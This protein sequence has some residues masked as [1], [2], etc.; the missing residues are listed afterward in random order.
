[1]QL[2]RR[3]LS[4]PISH[5]GTLDKSLREPSGVVQRPSRLPAGRTV[6]I[7]GRL[8]FRG[9][10]PRTLW[11]PSDKRPTFGNRIGRTGRSTIS[12]CRGQ[13]NRILWA[14]LHRSRYRVSRGDRASSTGFRS[15]VLVCDGSPGG[16]EKLSNPVLV[17]GSLAGLNFK[18]GRMT[19]G[20]SWSSS[21]Q[22]L[23]AP[24]RGTMWQNLSD[25]IRQRIEAADPVRQSTV[26]LRGL[27]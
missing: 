23:V 25:G 24:R 22:L 12:F 20:G 10:S 19:G 4:A 6:P 27:W 14:P 15:L 26:S 2:P 21:T 3:L 7:A 1:V 13:A 8:N 5:S 17:T 18:T 11:A 16:G 9:R